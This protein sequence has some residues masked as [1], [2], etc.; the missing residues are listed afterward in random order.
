MTAVPSN[1]VATIATIIH[2]KGHCEDYEHDHYPRSP[3][4]KRATRSSIRPRNAE[5]VVSFSWVI[6]LQY[7]GMSIGDQNRGGTAKF[8]MRARERWPQSRL[9]YYDDD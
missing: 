2:L 8:S 1:S 3:L 9:P 6:L 4:M 5:I 7:G